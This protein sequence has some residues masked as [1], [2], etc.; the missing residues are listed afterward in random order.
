M[1]T[2]FVKRTLTA[3][4]TRSRRSNLLVSLSEMVTEGLLSTEPYQRDKS[5]RQSREK[6]IH[7]PELLKVAVSAIRSPRWTI[8][9]I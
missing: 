7:A 3:V 8:D 5:V 2:L 6:L 1:V 4:K 9:S